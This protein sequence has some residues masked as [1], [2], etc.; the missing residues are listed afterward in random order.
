[1]PWIMALILLSMLWVYQVFTPKDLLQ[2]SMAPNLAQL[3][4]SIRNLRTDDL[5]IQV[6]NSEHQPISGAAVKLEQTSHH[7]EFGT[8]LSTE[9]FQGTANRQNQG[10]YLEVAKELF[11]ASVHENAFKWYATEP[12][13]GQ[14]SYADAD[15]ILNWSKSNH[16]KMRGHAL[17]WAGEEWNQ[18][19]VKSLSKR[20]LWHAVENRATEVCTRYRDYISEYDVLNEMLH[21]DFF[22]KKLGHK[23]V[24]NMFQWCQAAAPNATLYVNDYDILNGKALSR[25]V[26]QIHSLLNQ[27]IPIA[28]IGVQG[29]IREDISRVQVQKSLDTLAKIGLPIKI[30]EFDVVANTEQEQARILSDVYRVAFAHP[31]VT[32]ILMWGF[33]EG[34]HWEPQAALFRANWEPKPIAQAYMDLV[35]HEWWT[36]NQAF[37]DKKGEVV[38]RAFFGNYRATVSLG[39]W[40]TEQSL[41]FLPSERK[42]KVVKIV[43]KSA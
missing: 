15:N 17:F 11:N 20:E 41:S 38:T 37:T 9:M 19:W 25:Y 28:G 42:P 24:K 36:K 33:W 39:N 7:F 4:A 3:N 32:G 8:A 16:L 1:M 14:V 2:M 43:A 5:I 13:K 31:A 34:A 26:S 18:P 12:V 27:G 23:I 21:G 22:E 10:K 30:T 6:V 35:H 40:T 29:H